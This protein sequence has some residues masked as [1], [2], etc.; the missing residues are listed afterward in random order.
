MRFFSRHQ[1]QFNPID[2]LGGGLDEDIAAER[3][4]P[5]AI[6]DLSDPIDA[7]DLAHKWGVLLEEVKEDPEWFDFASE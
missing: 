5:E 4:E 3:H 6:T 2:P 1:I 7:Q